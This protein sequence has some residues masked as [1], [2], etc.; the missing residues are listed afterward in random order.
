MKKLLTNIFLILI[1]FTIALFLIPELHYSIYLNNLLSE[2]PIIFYITILFVIF[3]PAIVISVLLESREKN[4][5][6]IESDIKN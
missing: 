3:F 1:L 4:N 5:K 6:T 2:D